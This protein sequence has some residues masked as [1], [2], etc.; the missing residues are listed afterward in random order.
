MS[1]PS[2]LNR[3]TAKAVKA[4]CWKRK[5]KISGK[6]RHIHPRAYVVGYISPCC[7]VVATP[8]VDSEPQCQE[9]DKTSSLTLVRMFD[10]TLRPGDWCSTA[11]V[12]HSGGQETVA[13][14][15]VV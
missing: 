12:V 8:W 14:P 7:L 6:P 3:R 9:R 13:I 1:K 10:D 11:Y 4:W 15:V 2:R 5:T